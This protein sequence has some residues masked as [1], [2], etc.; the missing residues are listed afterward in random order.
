[1]KKNLR[2]LT[3]SIL[4]INILL[5]PLFAQQNLSE[6]TLTNLKKINTNYQNDLEKHIRL[7]YSQEINKHHSNNNQSGTLKLTY[8]VDSLGN[9]INYNFYE[10][11]WKNKRLGKK[12]IRYTE[13]YL[14]THPMNLPKD[15]T[16]TG[17]FFSD[18]LT[19]KFL[20]NSN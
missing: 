7:R 16:Y 4:T 9:I 19:F 8:E 6:N 18:T 13:Q 15:I 3:Q 20:D 14:R 10:I 12:I 5:N 2:L 1:M 11:I 17:R